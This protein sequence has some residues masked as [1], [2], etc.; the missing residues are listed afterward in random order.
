MRKFLP[1]FAFVAACLFGGAAHA[2]N[3]CAIPSNAQALFGQIDEE[4]NRIRARHGRG[5]LKYNAELSRAATGHA[6]DMAVLDFFSHEGSNG[7]SVQNRARRAGYRDCLIA[8][9]IAHG[10]IYASPTAVLQGWMDSQG[11]RRNMMHRRI[12]DY[13]I[14]VAVDHDGPYWVLVMAKGC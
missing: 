6:C 10:N 5:A 7:S 4:L 9:N 11:H 13:G 3:S 14:G 8:E 12:V 1:A 2:S